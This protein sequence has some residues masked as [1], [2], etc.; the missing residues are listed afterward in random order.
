MLRIMF[1]K[2]YIVTYIY[3]SNLLLGYDYYRTN[4]RKVL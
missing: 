4:R 1:Y 3:I 2:T